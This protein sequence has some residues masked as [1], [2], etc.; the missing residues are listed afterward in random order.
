MPLNVI[1]RDFPRTFNPLVA[2]SNPARPTKFHGKCPDFG[3]GIFFL[4]QSRRSPSLRIRGDA[5]ACL[6]FVKDTLF[7]A[8]ELEGRKNVR[9]LFD[10]RN[11]MGTLRGT[12]SPSTFSAAMRAAARTGSMACCDA[13]RSHG[14]TRPDLV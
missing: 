3:P 7:R 6:V 2:G 10:L 4:R 8:G 13:I 12:G 9:E 5:D 1:K 14:P 11:F